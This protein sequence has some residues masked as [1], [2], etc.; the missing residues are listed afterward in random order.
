MSTRLGFLPLFGSWIWFAAFAAII[1]CVLA[2]GIVRWSRSTADREATAAD[3]TRRGLI[4][5]VLIGMAAGPSLV[6]ASTSSAVSSTTVVVAVDVTGSMAVGDAHYGSSQEITRIEAARRAVNGLLGM[7]AGARFEAISFG[8]SASVDV[9]ATPDAQAVR[10][11]ARNLQVEPTAISAGSSLSEPLDTLIRSMQEIRQRHPKAPIAFYYISDGEQTS[12]GGRR[13]FS[14]LRQFVTTG[15]TIGVGSKKGGK[16]PLVTTANA[17]TISQ[18]ASPL[19]PN[20]YVSDPT[21]HKPG[22]SMMDPHELRSIAD[23]FSGSSLLT[24]ASTTVSGLQA[25]S[26]LAFQLSQG[27]RQHRQRT[28]I[29]WPLELLLFVLM[30]WELGAD[31]RLTRRYL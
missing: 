2:L 24:S 13:T 31:L 29:V 21:T 20:G 17:R 25:H 12:R 19:A 22:I 28:L 5:L 30:L 7:Y 27:Q 10:S 15:A 14:T 18:S 6:S 16:V 11:W 3:W 8:S 23:E 9:P 1:V 4:G 26:S